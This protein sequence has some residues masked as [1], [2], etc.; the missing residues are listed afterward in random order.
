VCFAQDVIV[1]K[2]GS[3]INA[4]VLEVKNDNVWFRYFENNPPGSTFSIQ[5]NSVSRIEYQNGHVQWFETE[6][7]TAQPTTS[8][9]VQS[10]NQRTQRTAN[11][12]ARTQSRNRTQPTV[13]APAQSQNRT[14]TA[15][16]VVQDRQQQPVAA[17]TEYR[18]NPSHQTANQPS[19]RNDNEIT[20]VEGNYYLGTRRLTDREVAQLYRNI[21][22]ISVD[23]RS[24]KLNNAGTWLIAGGSAF[25]ACGIG[26]YVYESSYQGK[27]YVDSW[28]G[29]GRF[30][31]SRVYTA[32]IVIGSATIAGGIFCKIKSGN[33]KKNSGYNQTSGNHYN[34]YSMNIGLTGNGIGLRLDF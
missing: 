25:L 11:L 6:Y 9:R 30:P 34:D 10:Q 1:T 18:Y 33:L 17:A 3:R 13:A 5:T 26:L 23:T 12:P 27:A 24:T 16:P 22:G 28:F 32:G 8:A 31:L 19:F 2:L 15:Q 29:D 4:N 7:V 20:V 14:T 21:R